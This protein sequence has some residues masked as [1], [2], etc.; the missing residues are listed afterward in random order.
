MRAASSATAPSSRAS[1]ETPIC[2]NS[3]RM[4]RTSFSRGT[5]VNLTG[6]VD[7]SAAQRSGNAAFLAP[8]ARISPPSLAPPVI[9]SLS[10]ARLLPLLRR[11]RLHR[12]RVDF[13]AHAIAERRID[14][15]V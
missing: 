13:H 2:D 10:T 9:L 14:E 3:D 15:L 4:V 1:S 11:E 12:Q 5:L 8:E 7:S 6:S